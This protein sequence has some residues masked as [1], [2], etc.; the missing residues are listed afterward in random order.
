MS[1]EEVGG[2]ADQEVPMDSRYRQKSGSISA[3][4]GRNIRT[5]MRKRSQSRSSVTSSNKSSPPTSPRVLAAVMQSFSRRDSQAS[6]TPSQ[7]SGAKSLARVSPKLKQEEIIRHQPSFASLSPSIPG[8]RESSENSILLQHQLS[9]DPSPLSYLPRAELNDPRI[10]SSKLSPFPGIASLERKATDVS[11]LEALPPLLHH[12]SDS[13]V[14]S[15]QRVTPAANPIYALPLPAAS[16]PPDHKRES[17]DSVNKRS[18]LAKTLGQQASSRSSCS[19]SQRSSSSDMPGEGSVSRHMPSEDGHPNFA[20]P[21]N[22]NDPF[23]APPLPSIQ[24]VRHR[25]VSP[26]VSVV[27]EVSEEGSRLTRFTT[28]TQRVDPGSPLF[29]REETDFGANPLPQRSLEI[30]SRMDD[31]LAL[32][33]DD[34]AR[35][36]I[37]DDP[38]RK[39]LLATQVLQVV[40]AHVSFTYYVVR[41]TYL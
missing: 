32:A 31:I 23:A 24:P 2:A 21:P 11:M 35:P 36:D 17:D 34:P 26:S 13:V 41:I 9:A 4:I 20:L 16:L 39:L 40:N 6:I 27:P 7:I 3:K 33:P 8:Q 28:T 1:W 38:P 30:L 18:W 25:S 37:L 12:I 14:P 19:T 5:A 29:E 10:H 15:Q 22:E